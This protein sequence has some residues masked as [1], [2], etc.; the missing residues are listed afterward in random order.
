VSRYRPLNNDRKL[1][2]RPIGR[3]PGVRSPH[4]KEISKMKTLVILAA[5]LL[6]TTAYAQEPEAPQTPDMPAPTTTATTGQVNFVTQRFAVA[7]KKSN[8]GSFFSLKLDCTPVDW[9]DVRVTKAPDN[10]EA[11]MVEGNTFP[12][13]TAPNPR[14]KCN[15]KS[16]KGHLLEYTPHKGYAGADRVEVEMISSEGTRALYTI[17]ISVK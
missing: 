2:H 6:A 16:I 1:G 12:N 9:V 8:L 4:D 13:Y 14:V 7:G 11:K 3:R 5:V 15:E 17:K 10:G